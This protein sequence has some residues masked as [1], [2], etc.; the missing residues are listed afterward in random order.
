MAEKLYLFDGTALVYRAYFAFISHPLRNS[1]G[2]NTSPIFGVVNS[3]LKI[4]RERDP[5]HIAFV[6]DAGGK[7]Q[8]HEL[9]EDYKATR[10]KMPDELR[11][12]LPYVNET[13]ENMGIPIIM[14]R[15][16]EADDIMA[17]IARKAAKK[18]YNPVIVTGD[19]D[20]L[21]VIDKDIHVLSPGR[22]GRSQE[23]MY[24]EENAK[25]RMGVSP[26]QIV[27]YLALV[28]D[29][30]D[31][32]PGVKGVGKKT[33][34]KLLDKY[35]DL[36]DIYDNIDE[37]SGAVKKK[38]ENSKEQAYLSKKLVQIDYDIDCGDI[39]FE[40]MKRG[41]ANYKKL[42]EIFEK[43]E[44]QSLMKEILPSKE[45]EVEIVIAGSKE[46]IKK[47]S[48]WAGFETALYIL[49]EG[50]KP[51]DG[52]IVG[53]AFYSGDDKA[54]YIP[55]GHKDDE[56]LFDDGENIALSDF[57]D[58]VLP[59]L[60]N[61]T[62]ITMHDLKGG[63]HLLGKYLEGFDSKLASYL[64]APAVHRHNLEFDI[65]SHLAVQVE[66]FKEL[67]P[68]R[69][70][71]YK[72]IAV[73]SAARAC[74]QR[75]VSLHKMRK[76]LVNK[77][78]NEK[79][80]SLYNDMEKPLMDV[81]YEMEKIGVYINID[82]LKDLSDKFTHEAHEL[83]QAAWEQ[84]GEEFNLDSPKQ[85]REILFEKLNLPPQKRTK[86]GPSTDMEVLEALSKLHPLPDIIVKYRKVKK[87]L[88]TYTDK[89]PDSIN[90]DTGRIHSVLHQA[91]TA[92]G[93]LSSSNPNLQNIPIRGE[94]GREVRK[95]F[96]AQ[97]EDEILLSA[98]YSQIELR[99][100]AHISDDENLK[101]AFI[102]GEDIHTS[103]A[104]KVFGLEKDEVDSDQR[105]AAKAVN[106]GIVYGL[107]AYGLSQDI[108][109]TVKESQKIIDEYFNKYP[110]V[111]KY[112][113]EIVEKAKEQKFVTTLMGRRRFLPDIDGKN[114]QMRQF[115]ERTA[116]NTPIQGTSAD[117][118]K[119]AMIRVADRLKEEGL[120]ARMILQI[121]DELLF[122]VHKDDAEKFG[123]I[124]KEIME[125][126]I[127]MDV[128]IKVDVQSG[129]SWA[130]I[131]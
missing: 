54:I 90:P 31:N 44:L 96:R 21:Q 19:K 131:H 65:M 8:R 112:M 105:S 1:E 45:T 119:I 23:T 66:P 9:Y 57:K 25:E 43:L 84:A 13:I 62:E 47:W 76:I 3:I 99:I 126:A 14:K 116:I 127:D 94:K 32:I 60:D 95:A 67:L 111:K 17:T 42:A 123:K 108:D 83:Q 79:L 64:L 48:D 24:T 118:I 46:D 92:T 113:D 28:G 72:A 52:Q 59:Y 122:E 80:L 6:F 91:V 68:S 11:D 88:S 130:D 37:L 7:T 98:D 121:H 29:S 63:R 16:T 27:D 89:L 10:E 5:E 78:E 115:S 106:Y 85:L 20:L 75:A 101:Q 109:F 35:K 53:V 15:G 129:E 74:C 86:T 50:E 18:G 71:S 30:S 110:G 40:N 56:K 58:I 26:S 12:V 77:L 97:N 39:D 2:L 34:Q 124:V 49:W 81:L 73:D 38:M 69:R 125:N 70:S 104:A 100:L 117:L 82:I 128:P 61:C 107:S 87:L 103:T 33:A 41:G 55:V 114:Y 120:R 51:F 93:R 22:G 4:L 102:D 36:D